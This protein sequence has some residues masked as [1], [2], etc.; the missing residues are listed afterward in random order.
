MHTIRKPQITP[1]KKIASLLILLAF[2]ATFAIAQDCTLYIPGNVGTELHYEITNGKGKVQGA[3]THKMI[4]KKESGGQTTFEILQTFMDPKSP[5]SVLLQDTIRF[6][7]K[8]NVFYIDMDKYLNQ[9]QMEAFKDMEIKVITEDLIYPRKLSPGMTLNDG[10]IRVEM[11]GGMMNMAITTNIV[12]RKV[13]AHE[14]IT[15]PAGSFKCYKLS[16]D[17]QSKMAFVNTKL[18]S[19]VWIKEN[20]GTIRSETYNKKGKLDGVTQLVKIVK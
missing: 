3:Y 1:M 9:S 6:R 15:T 11:V 16:E 7:C 8:D 20:I 4:S 19:V 12:N 18:H 2:T 14:T 17:I 13:E 10:S 5:E